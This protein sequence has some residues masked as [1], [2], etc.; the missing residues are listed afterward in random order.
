[1]TQRIY[2]NDLCPCGSGKKYKKCCRNKEDDEEF[3][4]PFNMFKNFRDI[5]KES[6]IKQCLYPNH[7]ECSDKIIGAHSI[8]N[9]KILKKISTNGKVLMPCPKPSTPFLPITEYGRKEASVFTGFCG[10]HDKTVFQPIEDKDFNY[11]VEQI[12]L[13]SYR[14]FALECQKKQELVQMEKNIIKRKPSLINIPDSE[15]PFLGTRLAWKDLEIEKKEF[16]NALLSNDYDIL[17]SVVWEFAGESK[18]AAT[19][20]EAI[21]YDIYNNKIQDLFDLNTPA[22]HIFISVFPCNNKTYS[23]ISW[24]KSSDSIFSSLYEQLIGLSLEE[25]KNYINNL[26]PMV[27]ENIVIN[28]EAWDKMSD[29]QKQG[30]MMRF[31]GVDDLLQID[32]KP[33]DRLKAPEYDLFSL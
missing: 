5:R 30:F 26:L 20:M 14:A 24:L 31:W 11:D 25:K 15:N 23:I 19:G 16:D 22:R 4:N 8:Q 18:F 33:M 27:T 17:S 9:N 28:P 29:I 7:N 32:G 1:M 6:R 3:N 13:F 10:Y 21:Q 2:P 12:F